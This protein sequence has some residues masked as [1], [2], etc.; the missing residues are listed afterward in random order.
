MAADAEYKITAPQIARQKRLMASTNALRLV[1]PGSI[2]EAVNSIMSGELSMDKWLQNKFKIEL[3]DPEAIKMLE[4]VRS[5][6]LEIGG[7]D[8]D[9]MAKQL[10]YA[11]MNGAS[12]GVYLDALQNYEKAKG[13]NEKY[14]WARRM[15]IASGVD[16]KRLQEAIGKSGEGWA[17]IERDYIAASDRY[18][19]KD[20][21]ETLVCKTLRI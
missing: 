10:T 2:G 18:A 17:D 16:E 12:N 9:F 6:A 21:A 19:G 4:S 8:E 14:I 3:A 20:N 15:A 13:P 1:L 5:A 7:Q 11:F